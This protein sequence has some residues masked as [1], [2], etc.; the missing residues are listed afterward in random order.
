[1]E[2]TPYDFSL[3]VFLVAA[4]IAHRQVSREKPTH[5]GI[6]WALVAVIIANIGTLALHPNRGLV[7][8]LFS[9]AVPGACLYG[10][11]ATHGFRPRVAIVFVLVGAVGTWTMSMTSPAHYAWSILFAWCVIAVLAWV[12]L[13][14]PESMA[15][16][17]TRASAVAFAAS[18]LADLPGVYAWAK[19]GSWKA[20]SVLTSLSVTILATLPALWK[21]RT[22]EQSSSDSRYSRSGLPSVGEREARIQRRYE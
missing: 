18:L 16:G 1:M 12:C 17:I 10:V 19:T 4:A 21:L 7:P 9:L 22:S 3:L 6:F 5:V 8:I 13:L 20:E 2:F 11:C 15:D 14:D